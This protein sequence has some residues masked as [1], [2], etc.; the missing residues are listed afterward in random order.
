MI[1]FTRD[2]QEGTEIDTMD[3]NLHIGN[4]NYYVC[5]GG[6]IDNFYNTQERIREYI[7]SGD[8][9]EVSYEE[10]PI[11]LKSFLKGDIFKKELK[12]LLNG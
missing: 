4:D 3:Y 5:D 11:Q 9:V 7:E 2:A 12:D 6:E 8:L 10:L 1:K